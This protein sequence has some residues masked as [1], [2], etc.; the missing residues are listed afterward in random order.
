MDNISNVRAF[1]HDYTEINDTKG[2]PKGKASN[3]T[4]LGKTACR[5]EESIQTCLFPPLRPNG[6]RTTTR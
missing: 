6:T 2:Y 5:N 1:C 4:I 3:F